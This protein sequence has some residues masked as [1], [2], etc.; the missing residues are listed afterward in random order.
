MYLA[1]KYVLL[2]LFSRTSVGEGWFAGMSSF[3]VFTGDG[4]LLAL[5]ANIIGLSDLSRKHLETM[6]TYS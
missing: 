6:A 2:L 3:Q 1:L 4:A 5:A